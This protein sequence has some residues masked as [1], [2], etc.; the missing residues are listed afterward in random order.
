MI[1]KNQ[2]IGVEKVVVPVEKQAS[3]NKTTLITKIPKVFSVRG[4]HSNN[5][6]SQKSIRL[7][8]L[9]YK[10]KSAIGSACVLAKSNG[11]ATYRRC[12][13]NQLDQLNSL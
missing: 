9:S 1:W 13:Q 8:G 3:N 5:S 10:D 7:D 12:V 6:M 2:F 4:Q 11:A